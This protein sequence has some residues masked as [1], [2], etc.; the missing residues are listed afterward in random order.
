MGRAADGEDWHE[1][2]RLTRKQNVFDDFAAIL[3]YLVDHRYTSPE[4]LIMGESNGGLLMG[5]TRN[6]NIIKRT[7]RTTR[8]C[9]Y[10]SFSR[11]KH[12]RSLPLVMGWLGKGTTF[13][14]LS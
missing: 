10:V 9:L 14:P 12:T 2:G 1:Q 4:K 11:A 5:A 6:R 3:R 8:R 7:N 13:S